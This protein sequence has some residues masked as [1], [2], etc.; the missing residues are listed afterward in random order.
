M[1]MQLR[2][3][4]IVAADVTWINHPNKDETLP[5]GISS[6]PNLT[7]GQIAITY[8][9]YLALE[10][11]VRKK[12][13]AA[14]IMED[15]IEFLS[16]VPER[17][18]Q[19]L[20]QLPEGWDCIFDSDFFGWRFIETPIEPGKFVYKKSNEQ[21]EQCGGATKGAHFFMIS[22]KGAEALLNNFLP[23]TNVS[24]HYYN[25]LAKKLN[26]NCYW[27][28]PPNIHKIQRESTWR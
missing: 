2:H 9:H 6:N 4:G 23:F 27:A 24:D 28:E 16:N 11:I 14:V 17:L 7:I 21:T 22:N 19:Y 10:D 13:P 20:S 25:Y 12:L 18:S 5:P 8:K 1:E 3:S 15:N 26:L